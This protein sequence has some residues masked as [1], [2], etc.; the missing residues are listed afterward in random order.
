MNAKRV[1]L[2]LF[3]CCLAFLAV[4]IEP[5]ELGTLEGPPRREMLEEPFIFV[6]DGT[7]YLT[8]TAGTYDKAGMVDF[9]FNRGAPL[10]KSPD[11][12]TWENLGYVFDRVQL[13][14]Q[15]KTSIGFWRDWNAPSERIDAFLSQATTSPKIYRFDKDWFLLCA[16]NDQA[17]LLQKSE[18]GKPQ[19]PYADYTVLATRGG[20]PSI[21][22]DDDGSRYLVFADGWIARIKPDMKALAEEIRPFSVDP[23][24]SIADSRLT[25]GDR[26]VCLFKRG[27][28]YYAIA[29]RWTVRSESP[30]YDAFLW[31]ADKVYGPYRETGTVLAG[32]GRVSVFEGKEGWKAVSAP[33][34][35]GV[36][37]IFDLVFGEGN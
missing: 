8:G 16:M 25:L 33:P 20:Y 11:L 35:G 26:G 9:D 32:A 14:K 4:A 18:S 28:K 10:W 13:L 30:S 22:S 37:K 7:Y 19:G 23:L 27:D 36:L 1:L 17:I 31:V 15:R 6:H 34:G 2:I 5:G 12:E 24:P 3:L 21:F 29:P